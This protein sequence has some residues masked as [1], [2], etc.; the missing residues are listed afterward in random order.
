MSGMQLQK[1]TFAD[2]AVV[3]E[4]EKRF[5]AAKIDMTNEDLR[6]QSAL[7]TYSIKGIPTILVLDL[8]GREILRQVGFVDAEMLLAQLASAR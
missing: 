1:T 8:Q 6:A 4:L 2:A 5:V 7:E 3:A